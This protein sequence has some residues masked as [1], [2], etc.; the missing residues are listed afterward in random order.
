[1]RGCGGGLNTFCDA[2]EV[3]NVRFRTNKHEVTVS[4]HVPV[5]SKNVLSPI[6][7]VAETNFIVRVFGFSQRCE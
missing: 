7:L 3:G 4:V 6:S 2:G 5:P 1:V